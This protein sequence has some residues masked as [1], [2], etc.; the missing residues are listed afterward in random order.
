MGYA[1]T[2]EECCRY[3]DRNFQKELSAIELAGEIPLFLLSFLQNFSGDQGYF[4]GGVYSLQ[5]DGS[6][7][8][9]HLWRG[10]DA[11]GCSGCGI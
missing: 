5:E 1:E 2:I 9:P 11:G 6:G 8:R 3:I 4:C 7:D 10:R